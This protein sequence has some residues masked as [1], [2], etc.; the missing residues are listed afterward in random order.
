M[1]YKQAKNVLTLWHPG[2]DLADNTKPKR[3]IRRLIRRK[4]RED[5]FDHEILKQQGR[6]H[7]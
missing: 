4:F 2:V 3:L 1:C 6:K 5:D 7:L